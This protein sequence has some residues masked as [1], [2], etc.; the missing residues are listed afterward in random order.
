MMIPH[1]K[2]VSNRPGSLGSKDAGYLCPFPKG[3]GAEPH[4]AGSIAIPTTTQHLDM[5]QNLPY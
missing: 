1:T 3:K 2:F 5:L 4:L